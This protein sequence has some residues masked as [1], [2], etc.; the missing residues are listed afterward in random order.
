MHLIDE[1]TVQ[2]RTGRSSPVLQAQ[3]VLCSREGR[4][5][6]TWEQ[7]AFC[8]AFLIAFVSFW[9]PQRIPRASPRSI[10]QGEALVGT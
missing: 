6:G 5:S 9:F 8:S 4:R 1:N 7:I 3:P 2:M 10:N